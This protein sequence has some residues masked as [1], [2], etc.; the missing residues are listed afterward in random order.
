M[1]NLYLIASF[2]FLIILSL[3]VSSN[4][5]FFSTKISKE[6]DKLKIKLLGKEAISLYHLKEV[7][8]YLSGMT[9]GIING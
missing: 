7:P 8:E 6:N 9:N 2:I 1:R 3:F 5:L 4:A